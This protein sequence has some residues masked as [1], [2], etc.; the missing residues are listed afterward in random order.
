MH[1]NRIPESEEH[2]VLDGLQVTIHSAT[3]SR[4][5]QLVIK[6]AEDRLGEPGN[7]A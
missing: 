3:T 4:I 7:D 2:F 5:E 1:T 6:Q